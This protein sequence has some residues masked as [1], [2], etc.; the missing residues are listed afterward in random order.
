MAGERVAGERMAGED[1]LLAVIEAIHAAGLDPG[2]WSQALA[3]LARAVGGDFGALELFDKST[4]Q[5]LEA[6]FSDLPPVVKRTYF[7][8]YA[9]LNPRIPV[10]LRHDVG[11]MSWDY[12]MF[13]EAAMLRSAYYEEFLRPTDL[14]YF[15]GGTFIRT[16][17]QFAGCSVH[18]SPKRGHFARAEIDLMRRLLPHVRQAFDVTQRLKGAGQ[19]RHSLERALD[20]LAD[21]V[22]LARVDGRVVYANE[23]MQVIARRGDGIAIK[24]GMIELA[25][26]ETRARLA[27]AL[28]A[29]GRLRAR[30]AGSSTIADFPLPRRSDAPPYL[31]AV[32]PLPADPAGGR[33]APSADAIIFVRDPLSRNAAAI[34]ILR[35]VLGLT[36]AEA[37]VAQALQA[38]LRLEDYARARAVSKYTIYAHLRSIKEKTGCH[39]MGELIAKLNDL[40][41][42]LRID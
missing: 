23:A 36:E 20:W 29:I 7:E 30:G 18:R 26:A 24:K 2:L 12:M 21:G 34:R 22:M 35:E 25:T 14:R 38:G 6:H 27:D 10:V 28:A 42:P 15:V 32:R 8:H 31:V 40:Q 11:Q 9:K 19:A 1:E 17:A 39:R 41:V 5:H 13:D 33:A 4:M 37:G 16:D 3:G